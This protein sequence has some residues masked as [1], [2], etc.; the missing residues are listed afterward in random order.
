M[1]ASRTGWLPL[2]AQRLS[3]GPSARRRLRRDQ[4]LDAQA[5]QVHAALEHDVNSLVALDDA[6]RSA[7]NHIAPLEELQ[8]NGD[9][10]SGESLELRAYLMASSEPTLG[11]ADMRTHSLRS[12]RFASYSST[13]S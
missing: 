1:Q 10:P 4:L 13:A 3:G 11:F 6:Q 9:P 8:G 7:V 2:D 12:A 5:A